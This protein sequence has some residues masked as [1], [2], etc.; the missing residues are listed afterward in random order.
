MY[1]GYEIVFDAAGSW[2]F[3]N[4]NTRN[5]IIFG[6]DNSS[7]SHTENCKNS[8]ISVTRRADLL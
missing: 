3:S 4:D 2:N 8:F 1:S 7:S 5:A 6:A